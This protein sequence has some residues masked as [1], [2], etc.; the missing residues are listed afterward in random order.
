MRSLLFHCKQFGANITGLSTRGVDVA[1]E[2]AHMNS[3][4]H[5]SCIVAFVT[6]ENGD[7]TE[8]IVPKNDQRDC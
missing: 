1:P 3:H 2:E 5:D 7:H 8:A 4:A 6:V